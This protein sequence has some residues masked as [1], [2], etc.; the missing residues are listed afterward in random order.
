MKEEEEEEEMEESC[1][2]GRRAEQKT[3]HSGESIRDAAQKKACPRPEPGLQLG[4]DLRRK[5]RTAAPPEPSG[6]RRSLQP[7]EDAA[8]HVTN[9]RPIRA[10]RRQEAATSAGAGDSRK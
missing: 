2:R 5:V 7:Q 1:G 9:W 4:G 10:L 6:A 3:C 8:G